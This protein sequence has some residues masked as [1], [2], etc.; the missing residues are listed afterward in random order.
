MET[1]QIV[2]CDTN[3]LIEFYKNNASIIQELQTIGAKNIAINSI[4]LAELIYGAHNK[5]EL[6]VILK[7]AKQ[8]TLFP[9]TEQ[10]SELTIQLMTQYSLS[11]NLTLPDALIA[12]TALHHKCP[13]YTLNKKDF[14]FLNGLVLHN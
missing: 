4:I 2:L 11:H 10:I 9:I 6:N 3:I 14:R 7:N 12:A 5:R 8:L 13:L 1:R